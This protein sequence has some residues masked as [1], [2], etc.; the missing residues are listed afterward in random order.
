MQKQLLTAQELAQMLNLSVETI[1]R[2]TR[3]NRIPAISLGNRQYRYDKE[4]VVQALLQRTSQAEQVQETKG[5]YTTGAFTYDD[6]AK[7]ADEPGY[8][9]E[10]I[11]GFFVK[12]PT[13]V[14]QHQ[15][16]SRRLQRILE[17]YFLETNPHGEVFDAPLD[18]IL[19]IHSTVQPDLI[20]IADT[21]KL[22]DSKF[23]EIVP[24]L[25]VEVL[26]PSS[27]RKDRIRKLDLYRR[28]GIH[29]YWIVGPEDG[30]LE[31]YKL[32]GTNYML[33]IATDELF[34]HPDFPGLSFDVAEL[35]AKPG[36]SL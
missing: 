9:V 20:Y 29:H 15:R 19:S 24:E 3:E 32:Q 18:V 13:P 30:I 22:A 4:D 10:L 5:L 21:K 25:V 17:D 26:S 16:I 2:Y 34:E 27:R 7:L 36:G 31:A 6:Y 14:V 35:T 28:H 33:V 8:I 11:D 1:W 12:E 23:I